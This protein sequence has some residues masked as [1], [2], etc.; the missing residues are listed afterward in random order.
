M[1]HAGLLLGH[2]VTGREQLVPASL[3]NPDGTLCNGEILASRLKD[4][5]LVRQDEDDSFMLIKCSPNLLTFGWFNFF[6]PM[7]MRS[8]PEITVRPFWNGMELD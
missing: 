8:R 4:L 1:L 5:S 2:H 7:Y 3:D 6:H